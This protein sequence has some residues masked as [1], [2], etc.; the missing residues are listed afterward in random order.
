MIITTV[1]TVSSQSAQHMQ[2]KIKRM[3]NILTGKKV[4]VGTKEVAANQHP[5]AKLFSTNV[6][7]QH[8]VVSHVCVC[9]C[10]SE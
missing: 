1:N 10:A 9:L 2:D 8:I 4:N 5:D 7:A 3:L 6:L